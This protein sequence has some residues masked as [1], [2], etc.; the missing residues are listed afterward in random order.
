MIVRL[1][2]LA[3]AT[4]ALGACTMPRGEPIAGIRPIPVVAADGSVTL[5]APPCPD[6]RRGSQEDFSNRNGS[7]FGC[8]D[9]VNFL[10]Q[11][12]D[13]RDGVR[14]R[15]ADEQDGGTAA[16][17]VERLR[18]RKT[19]PLGRNGTTTATAGSDPS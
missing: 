4:L 6:W 3:V 17:A 1:A 9:T 2:G 5:V 10:S 15:S 19:V 14:G 18:T 16:G 12:A 11:L 7:N 13:P 8:A